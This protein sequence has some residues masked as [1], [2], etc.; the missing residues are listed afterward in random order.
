MWV[1]WRMN[2]RSGGW[3]NE[4]EGELAKAR[5]RWMKSRMGEGPGLYEQMDEVEDEGEGRKVICDGECMKRRVD[6]G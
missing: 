6:E 2:G 5:G 3:I 1:K 4:G